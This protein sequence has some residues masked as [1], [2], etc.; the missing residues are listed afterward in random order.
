MKLSCADFTWPL[1]PHQDVLRL[2][3]SLD[4]EGLDLGVF[5]ER[6]H[7]RPEIIRQDIPMWAGILRER[8]RGSGLELA[9]VF[10]QNALDFET[11]APNNPDPRERENGMQLFLDMLE[12]ARWLEAPGM[13]ILPGARFG[14][15]PWDDAIARSAE[16]LKARVDAAAAQGIQVSVEGHVGS[17][18][19]TPAKL[20][21]LLDLTPGLRLTLDYTHDAYAG[22]ADVEVEPLIPYA[23][24]FQARGACPGK[25]QAKFAD[26][27]I[28]YRRILQR[29]QETGYAGF[30]AIEY[31]W[32]DW[33]HLNETENICETILMRDFVRATLAGEPYSPPAARAEMLP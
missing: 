5:A 15:E 29:L 8:I 19:D 25:L 10:V 26:N 31:V 21:R 23:R 14:N 2:I 4:I 28:D 24:H 22:I 20:A 27:T 13:T 1:L 12:L 18:V 30:F 17:C 3:H 9:D 16:G 7:I 11:M 6:S 33:Q 32:T